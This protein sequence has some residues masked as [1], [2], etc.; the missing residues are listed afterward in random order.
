MEY[1]FCSL[2]QIFQISISMSRIIKE[3]SK[4]NYYVIILMISMT[5]FC[6]KPFES[7]NCTMRIFLYPGIV[8]IYSFCIYSLS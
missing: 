6:E 7:N 1:Y 8:L 3:D 5:R 4:D 2:P